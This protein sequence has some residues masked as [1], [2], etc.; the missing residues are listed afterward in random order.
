MLVLEAVSNVLSPWARDHVLARH[1]I[2]G[3]HRYGNGC[4]CTCD[5]PDPTNGGHV[6]VNVNVNVNVPEWRLAD[7]TRLR[8]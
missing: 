8:T 5:I 7:K 2:F 3:I 1:F 4:S 6:N